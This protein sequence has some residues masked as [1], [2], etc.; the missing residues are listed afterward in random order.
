M[1]ICCRV[2]TTCDEVE[3]TDGVRHTQ[4]TRTIP[5]ANLAPSTFA[6]ARERAPRNA[7]ANGGPGPSS[8]RADTGRSCAVRC[9]SRARKRHP[10]DRR[11]RVGR[12]SQDACSTGEEGRPRAALALAFPGSPTGRGRVFHSTPQTNPPR[13]LRLPSPAFLSCWSSPPAQ[14]PK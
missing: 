12:T 10:S 7:G 3:D 4:H 8:G 6:P 5:H 11:G 2:T 13:A 1:Q 9:I 14:M